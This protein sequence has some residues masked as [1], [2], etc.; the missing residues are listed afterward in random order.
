MEKAR[1]WS[2]LFG[3]LLNRTQVAR[4][5]LLCDVREVEKTKSREKGETTLNAG[6][7]SRGAKRSG[8]KGEKDGRGRRDLSKSREKRREREGWL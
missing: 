3:G 6:R 2:P 7:H 8:S 5:A 1:I 4:P